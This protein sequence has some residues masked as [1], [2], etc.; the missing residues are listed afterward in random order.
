MS[1]SHTPSIQE[2]VESWDAITL[3]R[4]QELLY[5]QHQASTKNQNKEN[6]T[7]WD[8]TKAIIDDIKA[9]LSATTKG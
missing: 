1:Q 9:H 8:K 4:Q 5:L 2:Q 6:Q 3:R 7:E